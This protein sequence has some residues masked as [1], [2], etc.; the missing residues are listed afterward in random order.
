MLFS[1]QVVIL[2]SHFHFRGDDHEHASSF[3]LRPDF[4]NRNIL[5]FGDKSLQRPLP[6]FHVGDFPTTEHY[7]DLGLVPLFQETADVFDLE[8][9]VMVVGLGAEFH[10]LDLDM[11]LLLLGF[12]KFFTLLV[13]ELAEVHDP[14]DRRH[15]SRR[16]LYQVKLLGFRKRQCLLNGQDAELLAVS[17]YYP[18]FSGPYGLI[19]VNGRLSYGATS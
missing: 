10:F 2:F 3:H 15:R 4:D 6:K 19:D 1:L 7:G 8:C 17:P 5:K 11:H 18:D 14:A 13:F 9:K 16:H 12:L